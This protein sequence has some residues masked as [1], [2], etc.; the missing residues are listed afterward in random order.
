MNKE[1][2]AIRDAQDKATGDGR[3]LDKAVALSDAYIAAHPDQFTD[4]HDMTLQDAVK[5]VDV[6]R[7]AGMDE[8]E[9]RLQAWIFHR[10]EFQNIGGTTAPTVRFTAAQKGK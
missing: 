3:D 5:A 2:A 6:F 8:A 10:F 9:W 4:Y 1:L 7:A